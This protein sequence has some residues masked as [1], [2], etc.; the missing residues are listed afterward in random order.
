MQLALTAQKRIAGLGRFAD[1][2]G[3]ILL[4]QPGQPAEHLVLVALFGGRDREGNARLG[5][6]DGRILD[7]RRRV[8]QR[9]AGIGADLGQRADVARVQRRK[10]DLLLAIIV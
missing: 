3:G 9:I 7:A 6:R 5:K 4:L 8:A 2:E 10:L 1:G